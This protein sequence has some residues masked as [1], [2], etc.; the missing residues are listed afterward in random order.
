LKATMHSISFIMVNVCPRDQYK[1]NSAVMEVLHHYH[2]HRHQHFNV[3][4]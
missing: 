3:T 2:H 1:T 4:S